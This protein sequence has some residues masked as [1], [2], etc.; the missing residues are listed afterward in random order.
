MTNGTGI[1]AAGHSQAAAV[2]AYSLLD[3]LTLASPART[4]LF[5][6]LFL[7][8]QVLTLLSRIFISAHF[9]H[10]CLLGLLAGLAA[11]RLAYLPGSAMAAWC[12]QRPNWLLA[13]WSLLLPASA[14]AVYSGLQF[15]GLDPGWSVGQAR[16][17]CAHAAWV[18]VD[19]TPFYA[20][21]R[22]AGAGVGLASV[23]QQHHAGERRCPASSRAVELIQLV[24]GLMLGALAVH[25]H[26][27]VPRSNLILFYSL[28]FALNAVNVIAIVTV[29]LYVTTVMYSPAKDIKL[30]K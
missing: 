12:A 21:V 11:V 28:E 16:K 9:P 3:I 14:L 22:Y 5:P 17:Y 10:Q 27:L 20:L 13:V 15:L 26:A 25:L 24:V 2:V 4:V 29:P 30:K 18:H 1:A 8:A 7:P 6:L 19:T 23:Y